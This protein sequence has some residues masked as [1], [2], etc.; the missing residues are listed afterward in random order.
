MPGQTEAAHGRLALLIATSDYD[1]PALQQLRTPGRDASALAEVLESPQIGGFAV[2]T[3]I[4]ARCGELREAIEEFCTD[5]R[6]DDQ[7]LVYLSCHGLLNNR[8]RL[9][10]A[11]SDTRLKRAATT[12]VSAG[13]LN[14]RLDDC[15]ARSQI[16]ILDC[17]YSVAFTAD[18]KSLPSI[19]VE[20]R[21]VPQ[22]RGG[23]VVL[24]ASSLTEYSFEGDR[25]SGDGVP[26]VFTQAIVDGLRTG[27]ADRDQD[28]LIT[29]TEGYAYAYDTIRYYAYD[30]GFEVQP[31][32][33]RLWVYGA[34]EDARLAYSVRGVEAVPLP[35][36]LR[37]AL[38]NSHPPLREAAV[39][40]LAGILD[41]GRSGVVLS[42][43][44]ALQQIGDHDIP[45]VAAIARLALEAPQGTAAP[46][47]NKE[48]A[49]RNQREQAR[50]EAQQTTPQKAE[51]FNYRSLQDE[52]RDRIMP[53]STPTARGRIFISYRRNDT[54]W[55]AGWLFDRLA[56]Q[57]G[58]GQV[59]KDVDSIE[60]G[61]DFVEVITTAV[62]SCD[63]L[64]ALIGQGWLTI[65][66]EEGRR[67]LDNPEDFVRLEIE[68]ALTRNVRV[69]PILIEGARMPRADQLPASLAKMVRRQALKL[70]PDRFKSDTGQ[71]LRALDKIL[72]LPPG[73][74]ADI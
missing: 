8:E 62:G 21:L 24:T 68:A 43:R 69:I 11:A 58:E 64:L 39:A 28:G 74:D 60:L 44:D 47:V 20:Q 22:G 12:A 59:F 70:S 37:V 23:R 56:G 13:W 7:L 63:V 32:R 42:A 26:S 67:R 30:R 19:P 4:N 31:Q 46:A 49:D 9:Y 65:T 17:C 1:D 15:R 18:A 27:E 25:P 48:L 53:G 45:R 72:A 51:R 29:V 2:R 10:F 71:L 66:D 6:P 73:Y 52:L 40:Q 57:Y 54:A 50:H 16:V 55:T 3:L 34:M 61:D 36:A 41:T 35:E 33:P 14:E 38:E 5:L